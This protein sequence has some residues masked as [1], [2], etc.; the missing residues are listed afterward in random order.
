M[1]QHTVPQNI[2]SVE[3]KIFGDLTIR[4]FTYISI[5]GGLAFIFYLTLL[6][7][8][9]KY[10]LIVI[11]ILIGILVTFG[12]INE[13]PFDIWINNFITA[14]L[15][16]TQ[17]VWR[18]QAYFPYYLIDSQSSKVVNEKK[19]ETVSDDKVSLFLRSRN[20]PTDDTYK[21]N[22]RLDI[23][24]IKSLASI[25][26]ILKAP[27]QARSS[28]PAPVQDLSSSPVVDNSKPE[29]SKESAPVY[30]INDNKIE[31]KPIPETS[32]VL[33][34]ELISNIPSTINDLGNTSQTNQVFM[35]DSND[36]DIKDQNKDSLYDDKLDQISQVIPDSTEQ[37]I[38]PNI[39][40][41]NTPFVLAKDLNNTD[42]T[43][44]ILDENK[45][46]NHNLS[47]DNEPIQVLPI[48]KNIDLPQEVNEKIHTSSPTSNVVTIDPNSVFNIS[49][50]KNMSS[51]GQP[52]S[53]SDG[54]QNQSN[55]TPVQ[56][57]DDDIERIR[58]EKELEKQKE[59]LLALEKENEIKLREEEEKRIQDEKEKI[60]IEEENKI[61]EQEENIRLEKQKEELL[62][63]EREAKIQEEIRIKEEEEKRIQ[64]ENEK[65]K[66]ELEKKQKE[67][68]ELLL[69]KQAELERQKQE[70]LSKKE[71]EEQM[72]IEE[73][74][75]L[76]EEELKKKQEEENQKMQEKESEL[77]KF[78]QQNK[79]LQEELA[80]LQEQVKKLST[81]N[82]AVDT[83]SK[84]D[85]NETKEKLTQI[86]EENKKLKE[87]LEKKAEF[88]KSNLY[89][90]V[91]NQQQ[92]NQNTSNEGNKV[93]LN[94]NENLSYNK[95][96]LGPMPDFTKTPNIISGVVVDSNNKLVEDVVVIIKD[97][98]QRIMRAMRSNLL[99]QFY[100]RNPLPNGV[101][102][103]EANKEGYVFDTYNVILTGSEVE[104]T[105]I[106]TKVVK[107][108]KNFNFLSN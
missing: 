52:V 20:L 27:S 15:L 56:T 39:I 66:I 24:E 73:Q 81:T 97:K 72:R 10:P 31:E 83:S 92:N 4:Q 55:P 14:V 22:T 70:E 11:S 65:L 91:Q 103:I 33:G 23:D 26:R 8:I 74:K 75:R 77:V 58:K 99:G 80:T 102:D 5:A 85:L 13:R 100:S 108:N 95:L 90:S 37:D 57:S 48:D 49:D 68:E 17:R 78:E 16:P 3:F 54:N 34:E 69:K 47:E 106:K 94:N 63:K 107:N 12:K 98:S 59:E 51:S 62:Q 32:A 45:E 105:I 71:Q 36:S 93:T 87:E 53:Y 50:L 18:K 76:L 43:L 64:E 2:M 88:E 44:N 38:S 79:T 1:R 104:P 25:D 86:E 9:I 84:D 28:M 101:Y 21:F 96:N 61:K 67:E 46:F 41:P 29:I 30:P 35:D 60:R 6:P 42:E 89:N 82:D 40:P 7:G 19:K